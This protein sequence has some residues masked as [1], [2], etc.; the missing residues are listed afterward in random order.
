MTEMQE[1][2][3]DIL[4]W[5]NELCEKENLVYF[6]QGGTA[7]GA[8][9]HNG[10]IPWDDD[11]DV[12]M[13]RKY[14]TRLYELSKELNKVTKDYYIEFPEAK[15]FVYP[16]CKIYDKRT[17]LIEN[18]RNK[19]ERGI[20]IDVFPIDGIGNTIEESI[21]NF[22]EVD[23]YI[24]ML[25]TRVCA[26]RS[27][28]KWYKN[29]G[30]VLSRFIPDFILNHTKIIKKIEQLSIRFDYDECEYVANICGNWHEKEIMKK[31][32]VKNPV[33]CEFETTQIYI[34]EN[35]DAY[36]SKMYGDYMKLPPKEKQCTH[37]DFILLDLNRPYSK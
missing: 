20:Y 34:P 19:V 24:N 17:T 29:I 14:Y 13:P 4:K 21:K 8:V 10:F 3:L 12:G 2:L 9:R 18:T 23:K 33:L 6:A 28:R 27:R 35:C 37:H 31:D 22:R 7:L 26:L 16:Y 32:W 11:I 15:D 1:K 30:I 36:L 5:F 25:C